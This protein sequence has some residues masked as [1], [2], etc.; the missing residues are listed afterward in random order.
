[1]NV[2]RIGLPVTIGLAGIVVAIL[3]SVTLGLAL[4]IVAGL[5]FVANLYVRL[6]LRSQTDRDAEATRR[7]E[8]ERTGR[9]TED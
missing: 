6:S 3:G 1:M 9:W 7:A 8:F 5:V 4:V 2:L